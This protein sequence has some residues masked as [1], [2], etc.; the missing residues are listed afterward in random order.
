M[1]QVFRDDLGLLAGR[2]SY[3]SAFRGKKLPPKGPVI[4]GGHLIGLCWELVAVDT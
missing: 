4:E 3:T 2:V 1:W